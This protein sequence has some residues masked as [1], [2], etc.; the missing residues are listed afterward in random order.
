V[1]GRYSSGPF[2]TGLVPEKLCWVYASN[3]LRSRNSVEYELQRLEASEA[4]TSGR[5]FLWR[6]AVPLD[7]LRYNN[8]ITLTCSLPMAS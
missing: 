3:D 2:W 1:G 6:L 8:I 7:T 5:V 4:N